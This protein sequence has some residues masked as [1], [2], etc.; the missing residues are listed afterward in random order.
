MLPII[1]TEKFL[2]ASNCA[3]PEGEYCILD[4]DKKI[5]PGVAKVKPVAE[6]R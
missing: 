4:R 2:A 1:I 6:K 5:S 3:V